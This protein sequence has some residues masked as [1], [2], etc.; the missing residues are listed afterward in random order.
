MVTDKKRLLAIKRA[1]RANELETVRRLLMEDP[2]LV[3]THGHGWTPFQDAAFQA[4]TEIMRVM[5]KEGAG[6]TP[7]DI[8]HA[9]QH[10]VQLPHIDPEIVE[11][12]L[13]TGQVSEPFCLLYRG[14]VDALCALVVVR[15]DLIHQRDAAGFPLLIRAAE[16]AEEQIVRQLLTQ[17]ADVEERGPFGK[18]PLS[19]CACNQVDRK[20]R[21]RTLRLLLDNGADVNGKTF[22][23]RTPLF[24]AATAG[25]GPE[26][27][28]TILLEYGAD[29]S[30]RNDDGRTV[31]E[32]VLVNP[33]V[34]SQRVARLLRAAGAQG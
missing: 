11:V 6:I 23:G 17:G 10:A 25:W 14:E 7:R 5:L 20:K 24:S 19:A 33:S 31:L 21:S 28:V 34:R 26:D 27:S 15:G 30:V 4:R 8:A 32:E 3:L 16:N 12:L 22:R 9:L 1:V 18:S 2:H 29:V 13:A